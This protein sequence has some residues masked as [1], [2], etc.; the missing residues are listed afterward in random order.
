MEK[1]PGLD[2]QHQDMP[3]ISVATTNTDPSTTPAEQSPAPAETKSPQKQQSDTPA[4][5]DED[6]ED[7][8][9][10]ELDGLSRA[11]DFSV[12]NTATLTLR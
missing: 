7:S 9:F 5:R 11:T 2:S 4:P 12:Y 1:S 10:D 3:G 8:E 6:D